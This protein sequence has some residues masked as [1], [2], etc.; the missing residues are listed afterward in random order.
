[1]KTYP[2]R[3]FTLDPDPFDALFDDIR[4]GEVRP[5]T[6]VRV[7]D[8]EQGGWVRGTAGWW[9]GQPCLNEVN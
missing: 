4:R 9:G 6:T 7:W 1:V 5:G 3:W 8:Q 2:K